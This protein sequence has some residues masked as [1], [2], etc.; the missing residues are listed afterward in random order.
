V[1]KVA[2]LNP[3]STGD[4]AI[5]LDVLFGNIEAYSEIVKRYKNKVFGICISVIGNYHIAE[6]ITQE[7]F[8]EGFLKLASLRDKSK[9]GPWLC[10]IAKN[11]SYNFLSRSPHLYE[12][13]LLE[14][15]PDGGS[16]SPEQAVLKLDTQN[17]IAAALAKLPEKTRTAAILF[18][19]RDYSQKKIAQ[20]LDIPEGTVKRRL[21][22]AREKLKKELVFV[23]KDMDYRLPDD[24]EEKVSAKLK[25][26]AEYY[27]FNGYSFDGFDEHYKEVLRLI[28]KMPES[29]D[30]HSAY[31]DAYYI[32][33]GKDRSLMGEAKKHAELG[34]NASVLCGI[35]IEEII[36]G[37][38]DIM[39]RRI[40]EEGI[41][42]MEAL[43]A[44]NEKGE[45]LF[46]R[47][48]GYF[49]KNDFQKAKEGF[50]EAM[51]FLDK[52]NI[53]YANAC[54][55]KRASEVLQN[56]NDYFPGYCVALCGE[57]LRYKDGKL[58]F[59]GQPGFSS[60]NNYYGK[61]KYFSILYHA[62]RCGE[63]FFDEKME[64][65][66]TITS[67]SGSAT[68]TL[69]EKNSTMT[70][71]AG[72]FTNC[73]KLELRED[74][75]AH[76]WYAKDIGLIRADFF[77]IGSEESYELC[78][79]TLIGGSGYM[80]LCPGNTWR[81]K[82]TDLP[83]FYHQLMERKVIR[84]DGEYANLSAVDCI[85][86][87]KDCE[88]SPDADS[89]ILIQIAASYCEDWKIDEAINCLK[90]AAQKNS[91]VK[92]NRM[93]VAGLQ[94][95]ERFKSYQEKG[96]RFLPSSINGS[97]IGK[98]DGKVL[99]V[100]AGSYSFGPYRWGSRHE[101]N[102]IFGMKPFRY[103]QMLAGCIFS[104]K[105]V[106]GYRE[107]RPLDGED[108]TVHIRVEDGG[109]VK[110]KAGAFENCLK[111]TLEAEHE[112][113]DPFYYWHN[114][115]YVHCGKKTYYF[116]PNVGLVKHDCE[117]GSSLRSVCELSEYTSVATNGEYLP[118]YPG[119]RWIYDEMTLEDGYRARR[120]YEIVHGAGNS[121]FM[122]DEQEF[123]YLGTEEEY[124]RMKAGKNQ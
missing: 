8:I 59:D 63:L 89:D 20:I 34:E 116:A 53:Y 124:E 75:T 30:K 19:F 72:T 99:Y 76:L 119:C 112:T 56:D 87:S 50:E 109:T 91:S 120:K 92:A 24:F 57:R 18:Y 7:T 106:K 43:G 103:L 97:D 88:K 100:E 10:R 15:L 26:L 48:V 21:H 62:S 80:P 41:P 66:D 111:V 69:Q 36:N 38:N 47:S 60:R 44:K 11:K 101:E 2:P 16:S 105:W 29:K 86:L 32:A 64:V 25:L 4:E 113:K 108:V 68:L 107:S 117:W 52:N 3:G 37:D 93:A 96:F 83:D 85:L 14:W 73:I 77:D 123:L 84:F 6:D 54:A 104:D 27:R 90:I 79:Y 17:S 55:G 51:A 46:W 110:V 81:Y 95:L 35:L 22:D 115:S 40:N 23:V 121:Y 114:F 1:S 78:E 33:S 74:F 12:Y 13:E 94:Y 122:I 98:S 28:E 5:V 31:A 71:I 65:G 9:I 39:I 67:K 118:I 102:K 42:R 49:K 82:N 58:F 61:S 70:V 45:L